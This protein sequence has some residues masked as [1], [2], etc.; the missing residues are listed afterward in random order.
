MSHQQF[1]LLIEER[2]QV[3]DDLTKRLVDLLEPTVGAALE[4][5]VG[6]STA[7]RHEIVDVLLL[8]DTA[9]VIID[10]LIADVEKFTSTALIGQLVDLST[11]LT[12]TSNVVTQLQ[13]S[14]PAS[15][16]FDSP[17][18]IVEFISTLP[19]RVNPQDDPSSADDV[20]DEVLP[21]TPATT[22]PGDF[23]LSA[24][25]DDQVARLHVG[26]TGSKKLQ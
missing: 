24:L 4:Q 2:D 15:I 22:S 1:S 13:L 16:L 3:V 11:E 12:S 17:D 25:T 14:V 18:S 9:V 21:S 19:I 8:D 20:W 23:D 7:A 26:S 6:S 5:M 10:L